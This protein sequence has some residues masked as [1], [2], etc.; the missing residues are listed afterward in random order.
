MAKCPSP[1]T[2]RL[3][4]HVRQHRLLRP[5]QR[6]Q[7]AHRRARLPA[8]ARNP[9]RGRVRRR[10]PAHE[11]ARLAGP[12]AGEAH[13]GDE[14][15]RGRRAGQPPGDL[16]RARR[17]HGKGADHAHRDRQPAAHDRPDGRFRPGTDQEGSRPQQL[18]AHHHGAHPARALPAGGHHLAVELPLPA[19]ND[20][21]RPGADRRQRGPLQA[22][23]DHAPAR[24]PGARV[25]R[26]GARTRRRGGLRDGRR[27][28]RPGRDRQRGRGV[29]Y[30]Q[31]AHRPPG[32]RTRGK[33][34]H[35]RVPGN[36][37]QGPRHRPGIGRPGAHRPGAA[38]RFG[39][40][41]RPGLPVGGAH[42]RG[43]PDP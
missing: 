19:G 14:R 15:I 16:R 24:R 7:P 17:G 11:P 1:K 5:D 20:R 30:R 39:G 28:H 12:G 43:P 8:Q 31:R 9:R 22:E 37:R 10:P 32:R 2:R 18:G 35:S 25:L 36:G 41:N 23:R 26:P 21:F 4:V 6:P 42:L 33:Q 3:P 40:G 13:R 38:A 34:L 27:R 29:L